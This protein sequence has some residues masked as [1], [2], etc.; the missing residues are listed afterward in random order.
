MNNKTVEVENCDL[1]VIGLG[2]SGLNALNSASQY[3]SI[4]DKIIVVD[5]RNPS[6]SVGGMWN[7]A[8]PFV[9]LHQ[10]H[11]LFTVGNKKWKLNQNPGYLAKREEIVAHFQNCYS[12][13]KSELNITEKFN[14]EYQGHEEVKAGDDYEVYIKFKS[15]GDNLPPLLVKAKRCIKSIG[16][17]IS[18]NQPMEFSSNKVNS[19]I[20]ET[21]DLMSGKVAKSGNLV[22]IVGGGKTSMDVATLLLNQNPKLKLN[23]II[24]KGTYFFNRDIFF[25]QGFKRNWT[26]RT[27]NE[28]L[29][30]ITLR[31]DK[32]NLESAIQC[33]RETYC[34]GPFSK[35]THN[36]FGILSPSESRF[37]E[38][39]VQEAIYDYLNDVIEKEGRL[40]INYRSGK[41]Q[42]VESGSWFINCTGYMFAKKEN[43]ESTLSSH[44]KVLSVNKSRSTLGF[45][46]LEGYF[47]PHLWFRD[48]FK[49]VP[50]YEL[51]HADLAKKSKEAFL[52]GASAQ[53]IHNTLS[54]FES[55][56]FK[57]I[58][59]CGL[60]FEKWYP[61]HRQAFVLM[62]LLLNKK[63]YL[64]QISDVLEHIR[65]TYKVEG[66]FI[67]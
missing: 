9:R 59:D 41:Q 45:T 5:K 29:M 16:F 1:C 4:N 28:A 37:I 31:Y 12:D 8:Y 61:L 54:I 57:V 53:I 56:P 66:G 39:G 44:G 50:I 55:L 64:Y 62:K 51:N 13:L 46:S 42:H 26:G 38:E 22:Y 30:D 18:P 32:D 17:N 27:V 3:L 2:I 47:L 24:G 15:T 35:A 36:L 10:P 67:K 43:S 58:N 20:P 52:F 7:V 33:I 60:N 11:P 23:F 6:S 48:L 63:Q 25:P 34:V 65:N 49:D 21:A 19:I 40:F 14:Y